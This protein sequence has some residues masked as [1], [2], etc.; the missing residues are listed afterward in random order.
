MDELL[1]NYSKFKK[2]IA[3]VFKLQKSAIFNIDQT[4]N[5]LE[6]LKLRPFTSVGPT[7]NK[8]DFVALNKS[9]NREG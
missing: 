4:H 1:M 2:R 3:C 8:V 7:T 5:I 9:L 6:S